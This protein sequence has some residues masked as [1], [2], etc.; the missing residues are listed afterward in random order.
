M[1][2]DMQVKSALGEGST[3]SF[4]SVHDPPTSEELAKFLRHPNFPADGLPAELSNQL[5]ESK[6]SSDR[7]P[8]KFRMIGV[9]EDNPINLQ[10]LAKHLTTLGYQYTLCT[11]GKEM[12]DKFCDPD[13]TIDCCILDMSMPVMGMWFVTIIRRQLTLP[14]MVWNLLDSFANS[15]FRIRHHEVTSARRSSLC[16]C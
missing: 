14:Q 2:G 5:A 16:E 6:E 12:V 3:F 4:T 7:P 8:P 11:N 10:Y 13:S 9:A 1:G 15:S